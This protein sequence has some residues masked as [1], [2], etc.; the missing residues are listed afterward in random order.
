MKRISY[1][2]LIFS[3]LLCATS[4]EKVLDKKPLTQFTNDN[5]WTSESNVEMYANYFY[6]EWT[7][8]GNGN[9]QGV[10]YYHTLNDNQ[11]GRS[12]TTFTVNV[13]ATDGTWSSCYTEIRR[14]NIMIEKVPTIESM[15]DQAKAHWIGVARLYRAWQH[16]CLVRKFGDCVMVDKNLNVTDEDKE[17][18]LYTPR[19]NRNDVMDF[20]LEDLNFAVANI[21]QDG[22]S[23]V[24]Y[25]NAVAQ[26]IKSRI[27]LFEGTYAK[28][29]QNDNA[30]ANK[31]LNESKTASQAIMNNSMYV[32]NGSYR[33][34]YNSA[35]LSGNKEMIMYKK[36]VKSVLGHS[37]ISYTCSSTQILGLSKSAFDA[38]LF[39]DGL[40][41]A[42]TTLNNT[43][44]GV[45]GADGRI[46]IQNLLDVRDPRLGESIDS[47]LLYNGNGYM[48]YNKGMVST[49]SS[50]YGVMKFDNPDFPTDE[51]NQS[52]SSNHTDAPIFWLAEI[53]L[54]YAEACAE[55]GSCTDTDLDASINKLRARVGMPKL[56]ATPSADPANNMGV[57]DL[58]WEIRRERRVELMFD[59]ED[60]YWSLI[61]WKQLDKLDNGQYPDQTKGAWI[62]TTKASEVTVDA[63]G[64]IDGSFGMTRPFDNKYYLQPIPSGQ[65]DLNDKLT[66]NPGW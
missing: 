11:V 59:L 39:T 64:Y 61:R 66:Q 49:S 65:I 20:I 52:G 31:F 51:R 32:L 54:N 42:T 28:Y 15:T 48:R 13:P 19:N 60:R 12:F 41:K 40:P 4:C 56:S 38:Y 29:H 3:L 58:I 6:N 43:D 18:Y 37:L 27:C 16:F 7:G 24:A 36:Y 55:M 2:C 53:Y 30:R 46:D 8:Y 9:G 47:V 57:S 44:K 34:N 23:R 35:D 17:A 5:F 45:V 62:G 33:A 14:A 63:N 25:N 26:A 21:N 1:I 10:F 50:G 22:S